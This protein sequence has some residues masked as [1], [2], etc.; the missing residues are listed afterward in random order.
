MRRQN[1][2]DV[3]AIFSGT[4]ILVKD[5]NNP[6]GR[7]VYTKHTIYFHGKIKTVYF[8]YAHLEYIAVKQGQTIHK[9]GR[10]GVMGNTG[11]KDIHLHLSCFE[12]TPLFPS[13]TVDPVP[14]I[15][16]GCYPTNT[17]MHNPFGSSGCHKSLNSHE[18]CD[19]RGSIT[20]PGWKQGIDSLSV[21]YV[22]VKEYEESRKSS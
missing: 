5:D 18:G 1:E 14:Y 7:R 9:G 2:H 12:S 8:M 20:I 22:G 11:T 17:P 16:L 13:N 4:V 10:I 19:F 6:Y 3:Y 15:K 21:H